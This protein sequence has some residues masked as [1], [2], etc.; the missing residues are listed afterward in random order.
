[1]TKS[2]ILVIVLLF[3][4]QVSSAQSIKEI[5][6]IS[7]DKTKGLSYISESSGNYSAD[8]FCPINESDYAFLSKIEKKILIFNSNT[9]QK[10]KEINL[11][12]YPVD[13]TYS[14]NKYFVAGYKYLYTLNNNGEI[15]DKQFIDNKII[16]IQAVKY[17]ESKPYIITPDQISWNFDENG[18]LIKYDG[19][20][21]AEKTFAK[22]EK[23]NKTSFKIIFSQD[24]EKVI[25]KIVNTKENLGTVRILGLS[26]NN[27][28]IE[29]QIITK[30]IP[31]KVIRKICFY[32]INNLKNISEIELPDIT[33]TYIKHDVFVENN[34]V[35]F[36]VSTPEGAK[37]FELKYLDL[38]NKNLSFPSELYQYS[39][40]Y[41][42]NLITI[43]EKNIKP[44]N[45]D[46]NTMAAITRQQIIENA[47]PYAVYIWD[48]NVNNIK[49]YDCG[50]VHVTTPS[51]VTV[52][53]NVSMPYMWGGF[54]SFLQFD[55]GI[56][57]GVS[58][59]DSYTVGS[60]SGSS[61]AV[62]VDC[63]GYVS[64]AWDLPYKYGTSTL[65][66]ISTEYASFS[67][68]LPGDIVN[69]AGH[70]VRLVHTLNTDGSFLLVEAAATA[71]DWRVGYNNYT[72]ADLQTSYIPRYYND[73]IEDVAPPTSS[74]IA[75]LAIH[76]ETSSPK[77]VTVAKNGS[78][79]L[80][81]KSL[82][83][84]V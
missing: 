39:Y 46:K 2:R 35:N 78:N 1:M 30:E 66:N 51:W 61:C 24:N 60:G 27:L 16:F 19:I 5:I 82:L 45:T 79:F 22:I 32:S 18:T 48:C 20:I 62:G 34:R 44:S 14:N 43:N 80:Q 67:Q 3:I 65:P 81:N 52:G 38:N 12:F 68:L 84:N 75:R 37:I 6:N 54:S 21:L 64:R 42:N 57:N 33:Y 36:F 73:V 7:W 69:Y 41:N 55:Q 72:S 70:H 58:A 23:I 56:D 40:H 13:F 26:N 15:I 28:L 53:T 8:I 63:S 71:T 31:L 83:C 50:G 17:V 10:L 49:D 77:R 59:G 76:A 11:S 74:I 29:K 9:K 47:E 4:I 25:T